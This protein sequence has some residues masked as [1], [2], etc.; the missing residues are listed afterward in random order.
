MIAAGIV[1]PGLEG[2]GQSLGEV[3]DR[4]VGPGLG[5]EVV[6]KV[7][8]IPKGSRL[9]VSTNLLAAIVTACM[10]ATGQ[11]ESLDGPL[12]ESQRRIVAARAILG[13]WLAGS[14][15]GWQDSGG[16]W[17]GV[18]MIEGRAA[19]PGDPEF[20]VSRGRLLPDHHIYS[21][22]EV[23]RRTRELLCESFVLVHGGMA[24]NVGPIL[25]MVT[26]KYLLR[27]QPEWQ[28]RQEAMA[29]MRADRVGAA[30]G[31]TFA[32][33]R[34]PRRRT[35]SAPSR[36][37]SPGPRTTIPK[38]S[39]TACAARF[40]SDYWGFLMLGGISGGGMGF[41]FD[42]RRKTEAQ[43]CLQ[44][45]MSRAKH[46]LQHALP[47]AMEPVVYDFAVN[48]QGTFGRAVDR[49]RC[50]DAGRL[51]CP[52][53]AVVAAPRGEP[54][55]SGRAGR[56]RPVRRRLPR[57]KSRGGEGERG[58]KPEGETGRRGE[59]EM[60]ELT[61][62]AESPR[63]P[64]SRVCHSVVSAELL[65]SAL[66]PK[67]AEEREGAVSLRRLL[68]ENGFDPELHEQI[69]ADLRAGRIG[70]SQN[71]LPL[72]STIEDVLPGDVVDCT[73]GR[74]AIVGHSAAD[75][76]SRISP[77]PP[78]PLSPSSASLGEAALAG[79]E[80]AVLTL[81]AGAGS[82]WTQGAGV[83]K[84]LHPFCRF[85]GKYRNF[86]EVH[87]AK[88]RRTGVRYGAA[89]AA[90]D[91]HQPPHAPAD[92]TAP[93]PDGELRLSR[94]AVPFAG[95][96]DR[97]ADGAD[98]PRPA[99]RLAGDAAASARRTGPEG[100]REPPGGADRLGGSRPAAAPTIPTTCPCSACTRWDT[101]SR[102]P[103][104]CATARSAEC[105]PSG[106]R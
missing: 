71:R 95:P 5:L 76:D 20:G 81:A 68:E 82:R 96:L 41:S 43:D 87:L 63:L 89:R 2:S 61:S 40:A 77:S 50:A 86:I 39:S 18:K 53:R 101:G 70:L 29:I 69:R 75:A 49:R 74:K 34:G 4:L 44:D 22:A 67:P 85:Q 91:H 60:C 55:Q 15:G 72:S 13:E 102:S 30:S 14:G 31:A 26:E 17:P 103:T 90:G 10:R 46:E 54:A 47:F 94:P 83:V 92:R 1:P 7:N 19:R 32:K 8:D 73:A 45:E 21:E 23:G 64:V 52:L 65:F 80:V 79:G 62:A 11:I 78:L 98:G 12:S 48:D 57:G 16:I 51:L 9:A 28:A 99:L 104:C 42:P 25:E 37:S 59:G 84:A 88:S 35:F 36:P 33:S 106:P 105:W 38:R 6:S 27:C 100:P 66:F 97:P 3:L 93:P 58:R 24:Q 56:D